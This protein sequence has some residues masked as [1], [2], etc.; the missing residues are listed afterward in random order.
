MFNSKAYSKSGNVSFQA[1]DIAKQFLLA[2][3]CG[4]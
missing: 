3:M 2:K 4:Y 1:I